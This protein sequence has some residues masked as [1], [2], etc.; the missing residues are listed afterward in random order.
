MS[1]FSFTT[2]AQFEQFCWKIIHHM[3]RYGIS[4]SEALQRLNEQWKGLTFGGKYD[5]V[6]YHLDA[7]DWAHRIFYGTQKI[8]EARWAAQGRPP[9]QPRSN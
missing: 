2:D 4:E 1:Q 3:T 6:A 8:H 7:D 9:I 5:Y